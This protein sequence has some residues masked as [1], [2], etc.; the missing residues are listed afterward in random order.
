MPTHLQP[1]MIWA[2]QWI[3]VAS[4]YSWI[5]YD[6]LPMTK[7]TLKDIESHKTEELPPV[8]G[9]RLDRGRS[10]WPSAPKKTW[11]LLLCASKSQ[12]SDSW[13]SVAMD[14]AA[15][16]TLRNGQMSVSILD[17]KAVGGTIRLAKPY[18]LQFC[19]ANQNTPL[20]RQGTSNHLEY[21]KSNIV[22]VSNQD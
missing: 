11:T 18:M 12:L 7:S 15:N 6:L 1:L 16:Y 4:T 3:E 22:Q 14:S 13:G 10:W 5:V 9:F 2:A 20:G 8:P 19:S 21:P 17:T